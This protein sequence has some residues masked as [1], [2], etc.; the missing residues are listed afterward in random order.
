MRLET[1][2]KNLESNEP[3]SELSR[4]EKLLLVSLL[5]RRDALFWPWRFTIGSK[6]PFVEIFRRQ[7]EYLNGS[8]GLA[9]K[10]DGKSNWKKIHEIRQRLIAVNF[11][12]A[13]HSGGQVTNCF[14]T[15]TGEAVATAL[16]GPGLST[17]QDIEPR[18]C[19]EL[20]R[21]YGGVVRESK[22]FGIECV[23][24]P[25][26]WN[27]FTAFMLP[28]LTAGLVSCTSDT[29]GR[30]CYRLVSEVI[31]EVIVADVQHEEAMGDAY[32]RAFN[33]E[34]LVLEQC[35][36]RDP[37]EVFIPL[38]ATGWGINNGQSK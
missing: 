6:V 20:L 21:R 31:P 28:L 3:S 22:L 26:D 37:H 23:G 35:E 27:R 10:A 9:A 5:G 12:K 33:N 17:F 11:L 30:A 18:V 14:L 36:P 4:Q 32:M 29:Q 13:N 15:P 7:R 16:A 2:L 8:V 1:K 19:R 38:P 34:R 25:S 24:D